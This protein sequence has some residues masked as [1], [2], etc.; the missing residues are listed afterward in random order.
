MGWVIQTIIKLILKGLCGLFGGLA[1]DFITTF[2]I[3][4]GATFPQIGGDAMSLNDV[5][6]SYTKS[7]PSIF[8]TI[9]PMESF[10]KIFVALAIII[11]TALFVKE[12][13]LA[14]ST[15]L[16][17]RRQHPATS[18]AQ[19]FITMIGIVASYRIFIVMEYIMNIFYIKFGNKAIEVM[20]DVSG[21]E[22]PLS[23]FM[24]DSAGGGIVDVLDLASYLNPTTMVA[25][26][27]GELILNLIIVWLLFTNFLKL[28]IEILERYIVL[29]VL[30]YTSPLA[31]SSLSSPDTRDIFKSWFRMAISEMLLIA[32]NSI[33]IGIFIGALCRMT[34]IKGLMEGGLIGDVLLATNRLSWMVY[35]MLLLAWLLFAQ[36]LDSYLNSL[37]LSTAQTGGRL[38]VA[39]AAGISAA[40]GLGAAIGGKVLKS[41][42]LK[43]SR[44]A[45][46]NPKDSWG[47][48]GKSLQDSA[49]IATHNASNSL[50]PIDSIGK[51]PDSV[52]AAKARQ[53]NILSRDSVGKGLSA[54]GNSA[55]GSAVRQG[56]DLQGDE[57]RHAAEAIASTS[58]DK[59]LQRDIA[60]SKSVSF[61]K[62]A[63]GV[64]G[65]SYIDKDGNEKKLSFGGSMDGK[66][67]VGS[68]NGVQLGLSSSASGM[69]SFAGES[70]MRKEA[71]NL[72][73][74]SDGNYI[75]GVQ[76]GM[77]GV[78]DAS[79]GKFHT[80]QPQGTEGATGMAVGHNGM[81]LGPAADGAGFKSYKTLDNIHSGQTQLMDIA[82]RSGISLA[83]DTFAGQSISMASN[84]SNM[85]DV[86][87]FHKPQAATLLESSPK[88]DFDGTNTFKGTLIGGGSYEME[89]F[90]S[91]AVGAT[92]ANDAGVD[93]RLRCTEAGEGDSAI[94]ACLP[95]ANMTAVEKGLKGLVLPIDSIGQH[96]PDRNNPG[97]SVVASDDGYGYELRDNETGEVYIEATSPALAPALEK[98]YG[99]EY[100]IAGEMAYCISPEFFEYFN[101]R[102]GQD[103]YALE[104]LKSNPDFATMLKAYGYGI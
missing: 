79:T 20:T 55:V 30:F 3:N 93:I 85:A 77:H 61:G 82:N 24:Q 71:S 26:G 81:T 29:G 63:N 89:M 6:A 86:L 27:I 101:E 8:D 69:Q 60:N 96:Q 97:V 73:A 9:F 92:L 52:T 84:S 49:K 2:G 94:L 7:A 54:S 46:T 22:N 45:G 34:Q 95:M 32:T 36:R 15:P 23:N 80:L 76:G 48:L 90:N 104:V 66:A 21:I 88:L 68:I 18:V 11:A 103:P 43:A 50:K 78:R 87:S 102:I 10:K 65:A 91:D 51:E 74:S 99:T 16:T 53:E 13:V 28:L 57:A 47:A 19:Y 75:A 31:F 44:Q 62:D 70:A 42:P 5:M 25:G 41:T 98:K 33:F 56:R 17:G 14:I 64:Y 40:A 100:T 4:I 39:M 1:R 12:I 37:G 58:G 35:M 83:P 59:G 67:S 38:G 72:A